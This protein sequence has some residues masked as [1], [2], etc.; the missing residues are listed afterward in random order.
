M[1]AKK[2]FSENDVNAARERLSALPDLTRERLTRAEVLGQLRDDIRTL[3]RKKGY[4][5]PELR[6]QLESV[7]LTVSEKTLRDLLDGGRPA[8]RRTNSPAV[9]EE[10][11]AG[12][13]A[14][15]KSD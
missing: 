8:R 4:T 6:Q 12:G 3:H 7:G 13:L 11:K 14:G 1:A 5:L 2:W 9:A 10:K 15:G